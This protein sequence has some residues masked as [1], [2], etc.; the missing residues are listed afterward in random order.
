MVIFKN[1]KKRYVQDILEQVFK[2]RLLNLLD[3]VKHLVALRIKF[4]YLNF[5]R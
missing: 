5:K 1:Y 4:L 2:E 3:L